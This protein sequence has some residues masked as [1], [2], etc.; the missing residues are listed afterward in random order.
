MPQPSRSPG[1]RLVLTDARHDRHDRR[2][3]AAGGVA[4]RRRGGTAPKRRSDRTSHFCAIDRF[5]I[6][7]ASREALGASVFG[8]AFEAGQRTSLQHIM[9]TDA[10]STASS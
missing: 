1:C 2:P 7:S 5:D 10:A 6:L 3:C 4:L 9:E 8:D